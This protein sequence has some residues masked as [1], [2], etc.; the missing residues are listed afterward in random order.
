MHLGRLIAVDPSLTCSGW[1]LFHVSTGNLLAIGKIRAPSSATPLPLRLT[2][3]QRQVD[4]LMGVLKLGGDDVLVC[5]A[6]TTMKDPR[7]AFAVEQVRCIFESLGRARSVRVPGRVNPRSV[8]SEIMGLKGKQL[9]RPIVKE[10]AVIVAKALY[11]QALLSLGFDV[12]HS[13]LKRNQDIVDALLVGTLALS[14]IRTSR[15]E[16][17]VVLEELFVGKRRMR[18]TVGSS[19]GMRSRGGLR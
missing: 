17:S 19:R 12:E 8:Q 4:E 1:A 10:T 18:V 15:V 16:S 13:A 2:M 11:E 6:Q 5:E 3:L 9:A 14:K 7:A